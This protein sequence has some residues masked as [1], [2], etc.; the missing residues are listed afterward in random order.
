MSYSRMKLDIDEAPFR[1]TENKEL[2]DLDVA[3]GFLVIYWS[4]M[5]G[6]V[7][8]VVWVTLS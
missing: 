4:L 6:F 3:Y 7:E 5:I 2:L 1:T 8:F